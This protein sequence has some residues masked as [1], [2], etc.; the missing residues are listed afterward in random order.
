MISQDGLIKHM[1][2]LL[3][4]SI[5]SVIVF[6]SLLITNNVFAARANTKTETTTYSDNTTYQTPCVLSS[7]VA[8]PSTITAGETVTLSWNTRGCKN[9]QIVGIG[10]VSSSGSMTISPS[11]TTRYAFFAWPTTDPIDEPA[12]I[13]VTVN[14]VSANCMYLDFTATPSVITKGEPVTLSWNTN[15]CYDAKIVGLG[16]VSR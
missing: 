12:P 9:A 3:K 14:V 4:V 13:F 6:G 15:N 8:S 7:F 1:N 10:N 11:E 2:K 16:D 5:L